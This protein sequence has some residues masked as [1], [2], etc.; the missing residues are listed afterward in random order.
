MPLSDALI[1]E[2]YGDE[3][4][5]IHMSRGGSTEEH[6]SYFRGGANVW[7][8]RAEI[9]SRM[10]SGKKFY[11]RKGGWRVE[12]EIVPQENPQASYVRTV[13]DSTPSHNLLSLPRA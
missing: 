2:Y 10:A 8:S 6:V 5:A 13:P 7:L 11:A 9:I 1:D 12:L 3:V 4:T